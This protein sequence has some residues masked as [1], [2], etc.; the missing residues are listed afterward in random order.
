MASDGLAA[1]LGELPDNF[2]SH[3]AVTLV[4]GVVVF[5]LLVLLMKRKELDKTKENEQAAEDLAVPQWVSAEPMYDQPGGGTCTDCVGCPTRNTA[6]LTKVKLRNT[7]PFLKGSSVV[8]PPC[9]T[10]TTVDVEDCTITSPTAHVTSATGSTQ[11]AGIPE[12]FGRIHSIESF[13]AVDGH[14]IRCVIFMQGCLRR[15]V[16]CSN[17]DTWK[18]TDGQEKSSKEI[19]KMLERF[20]PY[21]K[22]SGGGVTCSGG[23]PMM[24]AEFVAA[25]FR[26]AHAL[27]VNTVMDTA[28]WGNQ[29]DYDTVLPHTDRVMLCVKAM[30]P[31]RYK[32]ITGGT[33]QKSMLQFF[34][35][36]CAYKIGLWI[37]L[38]LL[39][40]ETDNEEELKATVEFGRRHPELHGIEILPYHRLGLSKW[41]S[42]GIKY[43]MGN[44]P[45]MSEDR[46]DWAREYMKS[47]G[48]KVLQ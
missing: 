13:S 34:D 22:S 6:P 41:D 8:F 7:A 21:M 35:A 9:T 18:K 26:E 11:S 32:R 23:E 43:P 36:L 2:I 30:D 47:L 31:V 12:V 24:Q 16:F 3:I 39:A 17:P 40:G 42:L 27:G 20:V 46:A 1:S 48:V 38:V 19:A 33:N 14:G 10:C 4:A 37:R 45:A 29:T 44:T 28:G 25:V 15:C 5:A